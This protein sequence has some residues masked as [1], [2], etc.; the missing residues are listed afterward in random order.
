M[1]CV[2]SANALA[3]AVTLEPGQSHTLSAEIAC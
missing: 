1:V 2:E 3:N